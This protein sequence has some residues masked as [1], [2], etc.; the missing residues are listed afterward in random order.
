[1]D[2]AARG[3]HTRRMKLGKG[4]E[5][6]AREL[7]RLARR[8]LSDHVHSA[9][10]LDL[11]ML[12]HEDRA[13]TWRVDEICGALR[14]PTA[15]AEHR[16]EALLGAGL[17]VEQEGGYAC[18]SITGELDEALC[19]L[20]EARR[21]RWADLTELIAAPARRRQRALAETEQRA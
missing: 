14:C 13:R 20:E 3:A 11:L 12:V 4:A 6:L 18:V 15:W 2:G 21:T 10:E 19:A 7:P 5:M 1:M 17:L 8:L 16:L 9:G